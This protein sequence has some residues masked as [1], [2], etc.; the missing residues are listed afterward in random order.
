VKAVPFL[1]ALLCIGAIDAAL[2]LSLAHARHGRPVYYRARIH[3]RARPKPTITMPQES[4]PPQIDTAPHP[5]LAHARRTRPVHHRAHPKPAIA[6]PQES[7]PPQEAFASLPEAEPASPEVAS[8]CDRQL[9]KIAVARPLGALVAPGECGAPDAVLLQSVT[10]PNRS[11]VAVVPAATL[12]CP[13]ATALAQWVREDVAPAAAKLGSP[14]HALEDLGSYQCRGRDGVSGATLSEHG[15][16]NAIDLRAFKLGNGKALVLAD[17]EAPGD[18]RDAVRQSACARFMTVL[19]P[20]ADSAHSG[21]VH[22]D[23]APRHN[24]YKICEWDVR[25]PA[26]A[27]PA[28]AA[29]S[30]ER[31]LAEAGKIKPLEKVPLP[32]PRPAGAPLRPSKHRIMRRL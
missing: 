31:A 27:A 9:D 32:R 29:R 30:E 24:N 5:S 14:L 23:L 6:I 26:A 3:H 16:A 4:A 8:D 17:P 1:A 7:A 25:K 22:V 13:M 12:R 10:L 15:R 28:A 2:H 11:K 21:H 18:F 19:G 20:G